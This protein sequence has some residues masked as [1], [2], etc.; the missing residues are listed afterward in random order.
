M[1]FLNNP[2]KTSFIVNPSQFQMK[3]EI[4]ALQQVLL[5]LGKGYLFYFK[6]SS[7]IKLSEVI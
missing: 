4:N 3:A 6:H 7:S 1:V 5:S 2:D